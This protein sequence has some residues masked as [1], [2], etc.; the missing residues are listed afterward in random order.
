M[1]YANGNKFT[2]KFTGQHVKGNKDAGTMEYTNGDKFVVSNCIW[3]EEENI[4]K[5]DGVYT[6][7]TGETFEGKWWNREIKGVGTYKP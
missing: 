6:W 3:Y 2:G 7:S 1:Q 5:G 4:Q